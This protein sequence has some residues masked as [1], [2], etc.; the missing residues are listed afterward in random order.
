MEDLMLAFGV[1]YDK[2]RRWMDRGLFG[3]VH[4]HGHREGG[5]RVTDGS[6]VRFIRS[7]ASEYNLKRVDEEWYKAMAFGRGATK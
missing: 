3:E 1:H 4:R 7:H 2:V 5:N 6:V